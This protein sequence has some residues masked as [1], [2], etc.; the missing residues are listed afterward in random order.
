M[1]EVFVKH[2]DIESRDRASGPDGVE[3]VVLWEHEGSTAGVIWMQP[4]AE[5]ETHVHDTHDHHVWIVEGT[6]KVKGRDLEAGSYYYVP[7]GD[8]HDL[9]ADP[10]AGCKFFY[11][12]LRK[13]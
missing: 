2:E 11:L 8:P 12:Y 4:G 3:R 10:Q 5:L 1:E 6:G 9:H 13:G 7:G